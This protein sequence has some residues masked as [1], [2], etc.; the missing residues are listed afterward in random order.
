[1]GTI[2]I[3]FS[4]T[5]G[6][7]KP[8]HA[9]G[10]PPFTG[11]TNYKMFHYLTEAGIPYSRLH[12]VGGA[13]GGNRFVDVPN[14]FR[15]FEA[16]PLNPENYDFTFT[17]LLITALINAGVK[18][19]YRLGVTIENDCKIKAYRIHPPKDFK[20]WA[21]ICEMIIRHYNEGWANGFYYDI[22]YWEI[23]NEPE[24]KLDPHKNMMWTGTREQYFELYETASKHIKK[25][26]PSLK[27]GGYG[28]TGF[29]SYCIDNPSPDAKNMLTFFDDFLKY[30]KEHNCPLD[31]FSWH[32]YGGVIQTKNIAKYVS[33]TLDKAGFI[34]LEINLNEWNPLGDGKE[35][36]R[37]KAKHSAYIAGEMLALQ[38]TKTSMA[39]F[40]DARFGVS[41][42]G[43]LFN[44]FTAKPFPAY[45]SFLAFNELY[46]RKNQV[47]TDCDIEGI[48]AVG[49]KD[50]NSG[51]VVI[52][53]INDT[54]IELNLELNAKITSC[55]MLDDKNYLA[56]TALPSKIP[57]HTVL[58]ITT[59]L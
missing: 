50:D 9:V 56:E 58:L 28:A 8:L 59:D 55:K 16:D 19:F 1:M 32:S 29:Y 26:F 24:N 11:G 51:C 36:L 53:N 39:M 10:Q 7:I 49:A 48:F 21:V 17:D 57:A 30:I 14:I 47:K 46:I 45:Y 44:P 2:K 41:I 22:E 15:D 6:A 37:G 12:D 38:N 33:D 40:Y 20:K 5:I 23:W 4:K 31:F 25:R 27:V 54:E 42:Y 3:D 35:D 43:A 52:A 18:P 34:N 13:F